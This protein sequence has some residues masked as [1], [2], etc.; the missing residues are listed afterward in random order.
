MLN[1]DNH[2]GGCLLILNTHCD[3]PNLMV[4]SI[5]GFITLFQHSGDNI[6]TTVALLR[7]D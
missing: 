2:S 4:I 7:E 1:P 3:C 6:K 5:A